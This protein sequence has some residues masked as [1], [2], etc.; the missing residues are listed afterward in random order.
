LRHN[1]QKNKR[2]QV[3]HQVQ[4]L[5]LEEKLVL[6]NLDLELEEELEE[7][8]VVEDLELEALHQEELEEEHQLVQVVVMVYVEIV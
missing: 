5:S 6:S 2:K 7:E 3:L 1:Q 8:L 4:L